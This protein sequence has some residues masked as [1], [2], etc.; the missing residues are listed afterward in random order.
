MN[1]L[2]VSITNFTSDP[3]Q[4]LQPMLYGLKAQKRLAVKLEVLDWGDALKTLNRYAAQQQG[5][6]VSQIGTTWMGSLAPQMALRPFSAREIALFEGSEAFFPASWRSAHYL[7]GKEVYSL[8]WLADTYVLYY[9][10][11]VFA[12]LGLEAYRA[13]ATLDQFAATIAALKQAGHPLPWISHSGVRTLALVHH[14]SNW[15]RGNG[16]NYMAS[17]GE[18]VEFN[19]PASRA[20]IK[21]FFELQRF[22]PPEAQGLSDFEAAERFFRGQAAVTLASADAIQRM[23]EGRYPEE[24]VA[25][26]GIAVPPGTPFVGGSNWVIWAYAGA[27]QAQ[28][29][30]DFIQAMCSTEA[31]VRLHRQTG[32]LPARL[33]ALTQST[34]DPRYAAVWQTLQKGQPMLST[35]LWGLVEHRMMEALA[36]I[37]SALIAHPDADLIGLMDEHLTPLERMLNLTLA[38]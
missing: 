1:E 27:R 30:L 7:E 29:A 16:G 14:I 38:S 17:D 15:V 25:H 8:P 36:Q 34:D 10:K 18:R 19:T 26:T 9:R 12:R 22:I 20:G 5:P 4:A 21:Q 31:Q 32:V 35:R 33:D 24:V 6:V 28:E 3:I 37:S 23:A 2:Q 11:D 13:F